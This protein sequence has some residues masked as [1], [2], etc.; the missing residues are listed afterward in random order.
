VEL[1]EKRGLYEHPWQEREHLTNI[2]NDKEYNFIIALWMLH[3]F[4]CFLNPLTLYKG[5]DKRENRY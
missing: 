5:I 4:H 2:S 3:D 1:G